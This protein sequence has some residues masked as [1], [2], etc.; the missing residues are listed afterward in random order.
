M[1]NLD[2]VVGEDEITKGM[3]V[4]VPGNVE[5]QEG[6][7]FIK[8]IQGVVREIKGDLALVDLTSIDYKKNLTYRI[9]DLKKYPIEEYSTKS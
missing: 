6:I 2:K 1:T 3:F 4:V 8:G 5:A 7:K 9:S